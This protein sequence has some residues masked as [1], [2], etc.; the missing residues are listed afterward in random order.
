MKIRGKLSISF[1][2][3][4]IAALL[5]FALISYFTFKDSIM[6]NRDSVFSA[7]INRV[8][9]DIDMIVSSNLN[10]IE[11]LYLQNDTYKHLIEDYQSWDNDQ[12]S[13]VSG[14]FSE[15]KQGKII[16]SSVALFDPDGKKYLEDGDFAWP[17]T[18]PFSTITGLDDKSRCPCEPRTITAHESI[19][20]IYPFSRHDSSYV[21]GILMEQIK[22][23]DLGNAL[24]H[25]DDTG[26]FLFSIEYNNQPVFT[27]GDVT[28]AVYNDYFTYVKMQNI[29]ALSKEQ[30]VPKKKNIEGYFLFS[31]PAHPLQL[32]ISYMV[33]K[34]FYFKGLVELRSRII[35]AIAIIIW[36]TIDVIFIIAYKISKPLTA[37]SSAS[38][39]MI[40]DDYNTPLKFV[41]R[42]DEIGELAGNF[43]AMRQQVKVL[44][45]SDALTGVLNRRYF[46]VS[47]EKEIARVRRD[48]GD[49]CC[50]MI[51]IDNFK[52]INDTWGHQ[53]GDDVLIELGKLMIGIARTYDIMARYGGEEFIIALPGSNL[54]NAGQFAERLREQ[55]QKRPI[56]SL[57]EKTSVTVSIGVSRFTNLASDSAELLIKRADE[58][59]YKAKSSGKN[60]VIIYDSNPEYA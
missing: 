59:L 7:K 26:Q 13:D 31:A 50:L 52:K 45:T 17:F 51:D 22:I 3:L 28:D 11:R 8:S 10:T 27:S 53:C 4:V 29:S 24:T 37:L 32:M 12:R 23:A 1:S 34:D 46:M 25:E 5:A 56:P 16:L 19:F 47:L 42:G 49:L 57:A 44:T 43:E 9:H 38:K 55:V 21:T 15:Y 60:K 20:L 58:S 40:F 39:G 35:I 36:L 18:E 54:E 14:Y 48:G 30:N 2:L 6:K 33:P 41:N